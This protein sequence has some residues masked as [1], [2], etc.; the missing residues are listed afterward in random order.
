MQLV[1]RD[2][3]SVDEGW[4]WASAR[5]CLKPDANADLQMKAVCHAVDQRDAR[6]RDL[7]VG[8]SAH[9]FQCVVIAQPHLDAVGKA[10]QLGVGVG[11][12]VQCCQQAVD[13]AAADLQHCLEVTSEWIGHGYAPV[14]WLIS[15]WFSIS[16]FDRALRCSTTSCTRHN[17]GL[18]ISVPAVGK[19]A[20]F[21]TPMNS[22]AVSGRL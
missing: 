14:F 13:R 16:S 10:G 20:W 7:Y 5:V 18:R 1:L 19:G 15:T 22:G 9:A 2:H 17:T 3:G 4:H 21:S 6:H 11:V 8:Q 12:L